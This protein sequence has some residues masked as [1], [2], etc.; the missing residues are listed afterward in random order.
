MIGRRVVT[1]IAPIGDDAREARADLRLDLGDDGL[2]RMAVVG[3][4]GQRL[5][6]GDELATSGMTERGGDG[7]LDAELI[8]AMR[9]ALADAFDLRRVQRIDLRPALVL[10]LLA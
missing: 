5:G 3:I 10:A 6:V 1:A 9:L 2:Q 8:G 7:D 4:A